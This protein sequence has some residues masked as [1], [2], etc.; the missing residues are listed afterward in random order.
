MDLST[1][2]IADFKAQF[3]RDF[4]YLPV[5][6]ISALYNTGAKVYYTTT[7]LFYTA[8][9]DGVTGIFPTV[10]SSWQQVSDSTDNYILDA[11]I[12]AAF[13]EAL[14]NFNQSLFN[15]DAQ[16]RLC[17][18]YLAAHYLSIDIRNSRSGIAAV[19]AFPVQS[20]SVGSVSES[21][22]IPAKYMQ[23]PLYAMY[24]QTGYGMKYLSLVLPRLIGNVVTVDGAT[25][26]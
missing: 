23:T 12:T 1:I 11:D 3:R 15:S 9:N 25:Q 18:L 22:A 16:I 14:V 7:A 5:F 21:Y 13:S 17:Y 2:T 8:K 20:R 4:P 26:P 10:T 6:D 24:S 19:G